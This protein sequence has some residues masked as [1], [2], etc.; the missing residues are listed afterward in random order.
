MP[1]WVI[2]LLVVVGASVVL[3]PVGL[4]V[5]FIYVYGENHADMRDPVEDVSVARC[6][7]DPVTRRPVA[8]LTVTSQAART[9]TYHLMIDFQDRDGRFVETVRPAVEDLAP[10][11]TGRAAA[12]GRWP[13]E[14]GGLRCVVMEARFASTEPVGT[15]SP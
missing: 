8:E 7:V 13:Y 5:G 14:G 9:G 2:V 3:A 11:A 10:G 15:A 1:R 12:V 6:A 4:L